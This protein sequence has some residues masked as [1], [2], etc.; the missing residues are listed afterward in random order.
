MKNGFPIRLFNPKMWYKEFLHVCV[1]C[2][3]HATVE[4]L[5]KKLWTT[6]KKY[7][8]GFSILK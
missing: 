5:Y 4:R 7:L 6:L 1:I 8:S 3:Q 2:I